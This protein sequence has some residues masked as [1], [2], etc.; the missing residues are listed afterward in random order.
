MQNIEERFLGYFRMLE[1]LCYQKAY[2]VAEALLKTTLNKLKPIAIRIFR[3]KES[4]TSLLKRIIK[5]NSSK[6]NTERCISLFLDRLP[7]S[8]TDSLKFT[9]KDLEKICKARNDITHANELIFDEYE[10][11][12][13]EKFIEVLFILAMLDNLKVNLDDSSK[14][15]CRNHGFHHIKKESELKCTYT[16]NSEIKF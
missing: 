8:L 7:K 2:Y 12:G 16:K 15:I 5:L 10:L 1:S 13:F 9:K 6:Y 3:E 4:V 14:I 11:F